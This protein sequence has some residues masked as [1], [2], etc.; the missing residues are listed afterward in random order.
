M[1]EPTSGPIGPIT[2][3]IWDVDGTL[4]DT[5]ELCATALSTAIEQ[6]GGPT[7]TH[8]EIYSRFGP[9][10]EGV[11]RNELGDRWV[12]AIEVFLDEYKAGLDGLGFPEV[13][14]VVHRLADAGVP[15]SVVTGK[16]A[17]GA[18]ITLESLGLSDVFEEVAA[19]SLEGSVKADEI[20]R[21]VDAWGIPPRQVAYIGDAPSDV[22]SSRT[23]GVVAVTAAWKTGADIDHLRSLEPDVIL[24]TQNDLAAWV[25]GT[26]SGQR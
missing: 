22:R 12:D 23:A 3:V 5:L 2:A 7:L 11:L 1:S 15:Q 24:L 10:E 25:A 16:G 13:C 9:S 4:A 26:V 6:Y 17:R 21:I 20:A 8:Q 18:D 19:G 14:D